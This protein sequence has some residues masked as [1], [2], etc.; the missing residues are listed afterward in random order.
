MIKA[1]DCI[2]F[3]IAKANQASARFW[4]RKI[5]H[6]NV[7]AVQ[8]MV[9][10]HLYDRNN[11]TSKDIGERTRLDSATL[12]GVLDRLESLKYIERKNNPNDRRAILVCLTDEGEKTAITI[13]KINKKAVKEFLKQFNEKEEAVFR[14]FLKEI[15]M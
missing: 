1:E 11:V 9:L 7:T 3:Q 4:T 8:G 13:K 2:F 15:Q 12:T 6:L 14:S 5:S 10:N